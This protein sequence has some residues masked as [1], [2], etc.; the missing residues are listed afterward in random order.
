[1]HFPVAQLVYFVA[2][3]VYNVAQLVYIVAPVAQL[4]HACLCMHAHNSGIGC[5]FKGALWAELISI[6]CVSQHFVLPNSHAPMKCVLPV[7]VKAFV[8]TT[9]LSRLVQRLMVCRARRS[10]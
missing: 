10:P 9:T 6:L 1:M 8:N 4:V 7:A 5:F 3:L 2:Q